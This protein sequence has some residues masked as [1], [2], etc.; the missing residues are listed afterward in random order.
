MHQECRHMVGFT[1]RFLDP[2]WTHGQTLLGFDQS[3]TDFKKNYGYIEFVTIPV[4]FNLNF[5]KNHDFD[6]LGK[7][8][9]KILNLTCSDGPE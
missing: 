8:T 1:N 9:T 4:T 3:V 6:D 7:V 2:Q 5:P